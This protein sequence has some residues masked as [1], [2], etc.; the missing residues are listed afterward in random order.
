MCPNISITYVPQNQNRPEVYF[1]RAKDS[2]RIDRRSILTEQRILLYSTGGLLYHPTDNDFHSSM[3]MWSSTMYA[4]ITWLWHA[5]INHF[6]QE[7]IQ[8]STATVHIAYRGTS[9]SLPAET[10]AIVTT[11]S[12]T[13]YTMCATIH[14]SM[15]HQTNQQHK[16]GSKNNYQKLLALC[17]ISRCLIQ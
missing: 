3:L 15:H 16:S 5:T 9:S 2:F 6:E 11:S 17:P 14:Y 13:T 10:V 4:H 1:N 8:T 7:N 12:S